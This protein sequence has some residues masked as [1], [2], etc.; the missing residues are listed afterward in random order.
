MYVFGGW[1]PLI[2]DETK[3]TVE[4][5]W[6]C[7]N[8]LASL[9]LDTMTWESVNMDTY[10]DNQCPR[11]RAGHSAVAVST[12]LY[13]WSGRDGYRKAWNNQ[14]CFK[15]LWF[16]E[17]DKP[18]APSRVSLVRAGT[19]SLDVSWGPVQTADAYI[20]QIQKYEVQSNSGAISPPSS[21]I[22]QMPGAD[23]S[24][25]RSPVSSGVSSPMPTNPVSP[26]RVFHSVLL[27]LSY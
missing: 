13:V 11:A 14:V 10:D 23:T 1:V 15:D 12:R 2:S 24:P 4:K 21:R 5:E 27:P 7:T 6:K 20:L 8:S 3:S 19:N 25:S 9:N 16:L 26:F 18:A 22:S 17:T